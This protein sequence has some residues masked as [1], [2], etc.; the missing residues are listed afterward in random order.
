MLAV[1]IGSAPVVALGL[2][3]WWARARSST[4]E[5][6]NLCAEA[7]ASKRS[8]RTALPDAVVLH[9]MA[10]SRGDDLR[11]YKKVTAH[12]VIAPNG[13]VAQL[14][15]LSARL[16]ASH[17]FNGRS[18][19]IE[20]AGN[21]QSADGR[22]WRPEDYGRN[23]LTPAQVETG[24]RLLRL[25]SKLGMRF[26]FGHRQSYADRGN[27]PGPEIWSQVGQW[28]IEQLGMSDGGPGYF[29]DSGHPIPDSWRSHGAGN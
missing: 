8:K 27:D 23:Y 17:G 15:P 19:A 1:V 29:I 11:R 28:A 20:F 12:F 22:W 16:S 5:I 9:Q 10:L 14:H 25:L 21:L 7:P 18:V 3:A 4:L 6:V 2:L 13:A 26:V 24:R